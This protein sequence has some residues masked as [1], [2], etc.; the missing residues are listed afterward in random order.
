MSRYSTQCGPTL[1]DSP[2]IPSHMLLLICGRRARVFLLSVFGRLTCVPVACPPHN[3]VAEVWRVHV[4]YR[5]VAAYSCA[6]MAL[7][8]GL[9]IG[10]VDW[11]IGPSGIA[12]MTG[13]G[14]SC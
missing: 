12:E 1:P 3:L 7:L 10:A 2:S 13:R 9:G 14:P 11:Q 8:W 6:G 5:R 4:L